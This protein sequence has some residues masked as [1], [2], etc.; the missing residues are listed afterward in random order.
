HKSAYGEEGQRHEINAGTDAADSLKHSVSEPQDGEAHWPISAAHQRR[1][2]H[3]RPPITPLFYAD[4][5]CALGKGC[6]ALGIILMAR[7]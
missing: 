6:P 3:S 7:F 1:N 5:R 2:A 4:A